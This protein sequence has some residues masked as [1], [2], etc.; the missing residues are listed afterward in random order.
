MK[1]K[2]KKKERVRGHK[3][4]AEEDQVRSDGEQGEA[5]RTQERCCGGRV[6]QS[7]WCNLSVSEGWWR[8][9]SAVHPLASG[10]NTVT[11]A[12]PLPTSHLHRHFT[13]TIYDSQGR[14]RVAQSE[15]GCECSCG[16]AA[17]CLPRVSVCV[18][19]VCTCKC[20][21][22][23]EEERLEVPWT[24]KIEVIF[25][26]LFSFRPHNAEFKK[27]KTDRATEKNQGKWKWR[28][29]EGGLVSVVLAVATVTSPI[30]LWTNV[31][32]L[33]NFADICDIK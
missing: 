20:L 31:L 11:L 23:S 4:R 22:E 17:F 2:K 3:K 28:L 32:K 25:Y 24:R 33:W 18:F 13:C 12:L 30:S 9:S 16:E 10:G 26:T 7:K 29:N 21:D 15:D 5:R 14:S 19:F 8:E 1:G 6:R 27:I